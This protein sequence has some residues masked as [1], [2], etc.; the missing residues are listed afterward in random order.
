MKKCAASLVIRRMLNSTNSPLLK[1]TK[2]SGKKII[3]QTLADS[4][5]T[6]GVSAV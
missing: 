1:F 6:E 5:N 4:L 3:E 2:M